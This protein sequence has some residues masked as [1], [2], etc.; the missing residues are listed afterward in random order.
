MESCDTSLDLILSPLH[1]A[2]TMDSISVMPQILMSCTLVET[3]AGGGRRKG[4]KMCEGG[5]RQG[6]VLKC[7]RC[8]DGSCEGS[9]TIK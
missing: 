4:K 3:F 5:G 9:A 6:D 2:E 8:C 7:C 1:Q